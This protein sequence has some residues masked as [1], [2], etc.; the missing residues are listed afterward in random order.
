MSVLGTTELVL[1]HDVMDRVNDSEDRHDKG[2]K[3]RE[4]WIKDAQRPLEGPSAI[5]WISEVVRETVGRV[6]PENPV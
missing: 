2:E 5:L 3:S 1:G 6:S 4:R